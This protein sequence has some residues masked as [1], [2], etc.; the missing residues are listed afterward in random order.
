VPRAETE[1]VCEDCK[2][3]TACPTG[4]AEPVV[5]AAGSAAEALAAECTLC[6]A[7]SYA[8]THGMG[9]CLPC[10]P[11]TDCPFGSSEAPECPA[12]TSQPG[13]GSCEPCA[14]GTFSGPKA[15]VCEDCPAGYKCPPAAEAPEACG[16]GYFSA[17]RSA[18]CTPAPSGTYQPEEAAGAVLPC[19]AGYTCSGTCTSTGCDP[20]A[21]LPVECPPGTYSSSGFFCAEC[22]VGT[23]QPESGAAGQD[24][25]LEC[26]DGATCGRGTGTPTLCPPGTTSEA[27]RRGNFQKLEGTCL[28]CPA[29][30]FQPFF[31]GGPASCMACPDSALCWGGNGYPVEC[32]DKGCEPDPSATFQLRVTDVAVTDTPSNLNFGAY[33]E[34]RIS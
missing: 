11:G 6:P 18:V 27:R 1:W 19:P 26:E 25:C 2:A 34:P 22:E 9:A 3:G 15:A 17:A 31:G 14:G 8:P 28:P 23:Y 20:D 13:T 16:V 21:H 32:G 29:K 5:C 10:A 7:G 24:A 30:T 12:G 33:D 4:S